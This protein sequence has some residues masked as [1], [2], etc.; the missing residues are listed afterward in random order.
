MRIGVSK[1]SLAEAASVLERIAP[2][3]PNLP[4]LG[5]LYFEGAEG[6]LVLRASNGELDLELR[7]PAEVEG[8]GAGLVP[9]H[10]F[11]QI[12]RSLPG[13]L[14]A[15][16][17]SS[18]G[19][20]VESGS[21]LT[22]M[23]V[24]NPES[25]PPLDLGDGDAVS[26]PAQELAKALSRVRYAAANEEYRAV[27][28]GIQ[29]ELRPDRMR[30]VATDGFRLALYDAPLSG[31]PEA[32]RVLPARSADELVRVLKDASGEVSVRLGS[33]RLGVEARGFRMGIGLMEG[34]FPDYERV[35][36][37]NFVFEIRFDAE[38][39]RQTIERVRVLAD[40]GNQRIDLHLRPGAL[41]VAAEGEFGRGREEL[42]VETEGEGPLM[43]A[44]NAQYLVDAL[45]GLKG[46]AS[47]RLSGPNS[48]SVLTGVEDPGYLAVVVP[49]RV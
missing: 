33:A 38:A 34:E 13:E 28:R 29:L 1:R 10:V 27:F 6:E 42:P 26:L 7:V 14:A 47:F 25:F 48:P 37:E 46:Q 4:S 5:Y 32:K 49:L 19:L 21:F 20:E 45:K 17:L 40:K 31:A 30:A 22:R 15:L 3:R 12:V 24:S 9:A 23:A 43:A 39:L 35:V 36:P 11:G 18:E 44:F 8:E 2:N 41:E 16:E